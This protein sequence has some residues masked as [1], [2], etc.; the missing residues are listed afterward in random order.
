M[1]AWRKDKEDAARLC[2]EKKE[3]NENWKVVALQGSIETLK[4]HRLAPK[5]T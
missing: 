3:A 5:T 1:A 2:Y 4:H